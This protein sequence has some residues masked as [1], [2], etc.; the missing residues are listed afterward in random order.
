MYVIISFSFKTALL[1]QNTGKH[2]KK[3]H[4]PLSFNHSF[5]FF[6]HHSP[7]SSPKS[8]R[9]T[10]DM[11]QHLDKNKNRKTCNKYELQGN[12]NMF[13]INTDND[14]NSV[15]GDDMSCN[16]VNTQ[17]TDTVVNIPNGNVKNH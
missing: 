6:H 3:G 8:P 17:D 13:M 4:S 12:D 1:Q 11:K 2:K 10:P 16:T 7:K 9:S 15:D 14:I 5:S